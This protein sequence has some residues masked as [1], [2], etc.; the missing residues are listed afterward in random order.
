M[1]VILTQDAP[2]GK[3]YKGEVL[4]VKAGYARNHLIPVVCHDRCSDPRS[5][6]LDGVVHV[7]VDST[8]FNKADAIAPAFC[9]LLR[10]Q[11]TLGGSAGSRDCNM[12]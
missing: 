2:N 4:T 12:Y 8:T 11:Q 10:C 6:Q 5:A 9:W 3:A 1:R 7:V